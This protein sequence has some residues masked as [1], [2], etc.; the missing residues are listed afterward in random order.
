MSIVKI[1]FY[2]VV[3]TLWLSD[4]DH[5]YIV[6][7]AYTT[8]NERAVLLTAH[9]STQTVEYCVNEVTKRFANVVETP[10]SEIMHQ[11]NRKSKKFTKKMSKMFKDSFVTAIV[12]ELDGGIPNPLEFEV[13]DDEIEDYQGLPFFII[14]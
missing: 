3:G 4:E 13:S 9:C 1:S 2:D 10:L 12:L 6:F 5:P 14:E 11:N 7:D 8:K